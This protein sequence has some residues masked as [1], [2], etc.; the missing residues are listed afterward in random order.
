MSTAELEKE[1]ATPAIRLRRA[2]RSEPPFDDERAPE[3]WSSPHQLTLD[4]RRPTSA[5]GL[6]GSQARS[7][8][9]ASYPASGSAALTAA[10][11]RS[12]YSAAAA[13][14]PGSASSGLSGAPGPSNASGPSGTS[15]PS[16]S[17]AGSGRSASVV[18]ASPDAKLAVRRFVGSCVEVLNGYRPAAHLRR[19][20]Q[21]REAATVVAQGLVGARR[22]AEARRVHSRVRRPAPVAVLRSSLCEPRPGAVEAAVLLLI[23][24]RT[25]AMAL[26]LEQHDEAW[27]ATVLRLI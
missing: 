3:T 7:V 25:W 11:S 23:G 1:Q 4:W 27:L 9:A 20:A 21:P 14:S 6:L 5:A 22:V 8:A 24:D 18:G 26:R 19:L 16:A 10:A 15:G 13:S 2:P 12:G 17:S